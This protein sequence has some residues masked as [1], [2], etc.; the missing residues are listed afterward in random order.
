MKPKLTAGLAAA[1]L[2]GGMTVATAQSG[3]TTERSMALELTQEQRAALYQAVVAKKLPTPPP[4]NLPVT[5]GAEIPPATE[6]YV[7]PEAVTVDA[8]SAKFYLYTVAQSWVVIVDPTNLKV[9]D[10]IHP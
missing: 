6:L 5:V 4:P 1:M 10:A 9:V 8:P 2:A 7:L 3:G